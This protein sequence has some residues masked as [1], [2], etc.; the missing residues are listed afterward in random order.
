MH[1]DSAVFPPD[2]KFVSPET[3]DAFFAVVERLE[4]TLAEETAAL[5]AQRHRGLTDFTRQK[6]QG[7]LEFNR[8]MRQLDNTIPSQEIIG[9]L[10]RFEQTLDANA[11]ML[12]RHLSAVKEV[13]DTIVRVMRDAES[14]G[15][16]SR[17]Y[18]RADHDDF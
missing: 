16:Y 7:F 2:R 11:T 1:A 13:T 12:Q 10:S 17:A 3:F 14:D 6:R 5:A 15:T 4:S 18:G 9:R 8:I